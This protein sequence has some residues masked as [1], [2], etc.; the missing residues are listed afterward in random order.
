MREGGSLSVAIWFSLGQYLI[1]KTYREVRWRRPLQFNVSIVLNPFRYRVLA[2]TRCLRLG[3][4][5]NGKD[6]SE[7]QML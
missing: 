6:E 1:V 4:A 3:N 5:S 7:S 2:I